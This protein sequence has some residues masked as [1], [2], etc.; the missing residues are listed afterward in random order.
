MDE[1]QKHIIAHA[2]KMNR[3]EQGLALE[4]LAEMAGLAVAEL[5]AIEA[6][7]FAVTGVHVNAIADALGV[8]NWVLM[9]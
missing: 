4:E 6:E 5:E 2:V 8:A 9:V 1:K 7:E 3:I